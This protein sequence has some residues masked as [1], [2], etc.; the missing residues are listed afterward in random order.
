V[1]T[2]AMLAAGR[3]LSDPRLSPDGAHVAFVSS[4]GGRAAIVVVSAAGGPERRVTSEPEPRTGRLTSGAVL[5]WLPDGSGIVYSCARGSTIVY[6]P[7]YNLWLAK[8]SG[9]ARRRH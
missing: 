1:I 6:L 7:T 8:L 4:S 3:E 5:D 9:L 2:A